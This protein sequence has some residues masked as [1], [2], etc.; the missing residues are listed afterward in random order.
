MTDAVRDQLRQHF[1]SGNTPDR[2]DDAWTQ[3]LTPWD[4][5]ASNPALVDLLNTRHDLLGDPFTQGAD[6]QRQRKKALVPGC[7]RGYDVLLLASF[8]YDAVGI[9]GSETAIEA[10]KKLANEEADKYPLHNSTESRGNITFLVGD[11]FETN[12][13]SSLHP[14]GGIVSFDLIYDYTV[15]FHI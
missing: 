4:R 7:G 1:L 3:S 13:Q 5:G 8:G 11:F 6:G 9:D 15:C 12:W 10:C 14:Q 2:W